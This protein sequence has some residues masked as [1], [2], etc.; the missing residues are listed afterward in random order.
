MTL[1]TWKAREIKRLCQL[2]V[3]YDDP[4]PERVEACIAKLEIQVKHLTEDEDVLVTE[5][6]DEVLKSIQSCE[7][8][9]AR[10]ALEER[11]KQEDEEEEG[12]EKYGSKT[13]R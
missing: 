3:D 9:A 13:W 10:D 4:T 2:P 5:E 8:S 11:G 6:E 7:E 1:R 12:E